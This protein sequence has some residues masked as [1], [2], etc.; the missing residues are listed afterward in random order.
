MTLTRNQLLVIPGWDAIYWEIYATTACNLRCSYC[1]NVTQQ[2]NTEPCY[3]IGE[4]VSFL[5]KYARKGDSIS[6]IGGEPSIRTGWISGVISETRA[7]DFRY[8]I[9]TNG[10]SLGKFPPD[11]LNRFDNILVSIDGDEEQNDRY[12]GQGTF[13]KVIENLEI[14]RPVFKGKI[15]ARMTATA[16]NN[17]EKS[18]KALTALPYFDTVYWQYE[19]RK[20]FHAYPT[21]QKW[22]E[23]RNLTDFWVENLEQG[24]FIH[25]QTFVSIVVR[26]LDQEGNQAYHNEDYSLPHFTLGCGA[27]HHYMQ[28]Y[29]T[30][31][32]YACPELV[33]QSCNLMG[34]I[35][36]GITQSVRIGDFSN[37]DKCPQCP[38]FEVCHCRC[39]HCTPCE[40]CS[41]LK[42]TIAELRK[43]LPLIKAL[44]D[45]GTIDKEDFYISEHLEEM[46]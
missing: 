18:V 24:R 9:Y 4:L 38:E 30:G 14:A 45:S 26:L 39:L 22:D 17:V 20:D 23:I 7:F 27:G 36:T 21:E 3:T 10:I 2:E 34:D 13:S 15:I 8:Q 12:R 40:Y 41:L 32:I 42:R 25:L 44:I 37:T 19:N 35:Y 33:G 5:K 16:D 29:I 11:F 1:Y 43:K 6:F 46:F 31:D 28:I